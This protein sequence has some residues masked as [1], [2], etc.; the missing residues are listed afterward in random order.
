MYHTID[1]R[2]DLQLSPGDRLFLYSDGIVEC[3]NSQGEMFG[4]EKLKS[5]L[6]ESQ[7]LP[8]NDMITVVQRQIEDW[9]GHDQFDDDVTYLI[10][11]WKP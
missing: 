10:M 3:E 6:K 11:E 1:H 2:N 8:M 7:A 5:L 4:Q 9:Q